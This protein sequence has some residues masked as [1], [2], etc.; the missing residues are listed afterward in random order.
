MK[1]ICDMTDYDKTYAPIPFSDETFFSGANTRSGFK[2]LFSDLF[3][4]ADLDALYIIKGGPGTGKSTFMK[5]LALA[6]KERG[7]HTCTYFCG[8]DPDSLDAVTAALG[9]KSIAIIDGTSPHAYDARFPGA[10]SRILDF[11][12]FWDE[13]KLRPDRDKIITLAT[14]KS[15][16]YTRAYRYLNA[17]AVIRFDVREISAKALDT[18]KM[19]SACTRLAAGFAKDH[20]TASPTVR[21]RTFEGTTMRGIC[22]IDF[23]PDTALISVTDVEWT[24][25]FFMSALSDALTAAG[26]S[27]TVLSDSTEPDIIRGLYIDSAR[28]RV[29][30]FAKKPDGAVKNVNMARFVSTD[31][32]KNS[33]NKRSFAR[34]C[35]ASVADGARE[36]LAEAAK[37]HFTLEEIYKQAMDFAAL[38][39]QSKIW[40]EEIL[41]R[42]D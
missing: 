17:L 34:K 11:G 29:F 7:A 25:P 12:T 13:S 42:L 2:N 24:Y 27:H 33:R 3:D 8:S 20:A 9:D 6:A 30:P 41:S 32:L 26:V 15:N 10:V 4:E 1:G 39:A 31:K 5:K 38:T 18:V 28:I 23:A 22:S 19:R 16:C 35:A 40:T 37:Y 21:R 14:A 36:S